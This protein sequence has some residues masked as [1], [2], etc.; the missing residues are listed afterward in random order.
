MYQYREGQVKRASFALAIG[1]FLLAYICAFVQE[2]TPTDRVT[3]PDHG[4]IKGLV[5]DRQI[6][7]PNGL[8]GATITAESEVSFGDRAITA[9]TDS[10]GHYEV[11]DLPPGEY[12]V[13]VSKPGY[14]DSMDYVTVTPGGWAFHDVRLYK[15]NVLIILFREMRVLW[16][17][18]LIC[19]VVVIIYLI[20]RRSSSETQNG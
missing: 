17:L 5:T 13:T 15:T 10:A 4:L 6:P 2:G 16:G 8:A 18:L 1:S 14:D 12:V 9:T 7:R 19:L 20:R 11:P 3:A